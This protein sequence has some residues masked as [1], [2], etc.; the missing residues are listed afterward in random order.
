MTNALRVLNMRQTITKNDKLSQTQYAYPVLF[1]NLCI[2]AVL[3]VLYMNH[4]WKNNAWID[5]YM[6]II[7]I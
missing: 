7:L 4:A 3:C 2:L 5:D 6:L 1:T